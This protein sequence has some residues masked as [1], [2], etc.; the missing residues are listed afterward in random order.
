MQ[1]TFTRSDASIFADPITGVLTTD[2]AASSYGLPVFV[3]T[4]GEVIS[5]SAYGTISP[6]CQCY[7]DDGKTVLSEIATMLRYARLAGYRTIEM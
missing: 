6:D 4:D 3:T 1:A 5:P 7:Q 2:H